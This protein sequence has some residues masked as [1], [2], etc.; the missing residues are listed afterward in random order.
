[1]APNG[2]LVAL[3]NIAAIPP[4]IF[5]QA[6]PDKIAVGQS[7]TLSWVVQGA[8]SQSLDEGI[9]GVA[10]TGS[11]VVTPDATTFYHLTAVNDTNPSDVLKTTAYAEIEVV[12]NQAAFALQKLI[13]TL[14]Q[15]RIP[16]RGRNGGGG[17]R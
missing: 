12:S 4:K 17:Q 1:L 3:E 6:V 13:L 15:D 9:G 16:V 2:L 7:S 8:T 10:A 5:L 11:L 14:K